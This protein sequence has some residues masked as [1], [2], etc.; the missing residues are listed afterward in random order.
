[1]YR[2]GKNMSRQFFVDMNVKLCKYVLDSMKDVELFMLPHV[3]NDSIKG[4]AHIMMDI[5]NKIPQEYKERIILKNESMQ[6]YEVREVI[7]KSYFL[8]A[9]R[10]HPAISGLECGV[11]SLVFSYGRKYEGIF[12]NLY[13][14]EDTILDIREY[15][16][17]DSIMK[18]AERLVNYIVENNESLRE[19]I[20]NKNVL[21]RPRALAHIQE[22]VEE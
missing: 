18:E 5:Y 13:E 2:H 9:E 1:M 15:S 6:P 4:D 11:P 17:D 21:A 16:E 3:W 22:I 20:R 19:R 7:K 10:M 12:G 8:I 14:L